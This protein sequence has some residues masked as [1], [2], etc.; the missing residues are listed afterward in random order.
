[1]EQGAGSREEEGREGRRW[2][3]DKERAVGGG[4]IRLKDPLKKGVSENGCEGEGWPGEV[5]RL[6]DETPAVMGHGSNAGAFW[7]MGECRERIVE[8]ETP[9]VMDHGSGSD[10]RLRAADFMARV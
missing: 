3:K 10:D 6:A 1:V 4:W 2:K 5:G 8:V 9:V 7:C